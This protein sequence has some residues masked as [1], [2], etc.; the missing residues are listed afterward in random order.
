MSN[1]SSILL[2]PLSDVQ[3]DSIGLRTSIWQYVVILPGAVIGSDCNIGAHCFIE[4]DVVI[5]NRVTVKNGV[6]L[7]DGVVLEDD[8]FIGPNVTF[9]NDMYPRSR[10]RVDI[11]PRTTVRKGASIGGGVVLLP[12]VTVGE[13]AL[14]G[15]GAVVTKPVPPFAVVVGNPFRQIGEVSLRNTL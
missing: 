8:V 4:N 12:G 3:T 5:G 13:G 14:V 1:A 11:F 7:W 10:Q 9:T 2:H 6:S 15:A